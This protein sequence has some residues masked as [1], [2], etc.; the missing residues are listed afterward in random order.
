MHSLWR[1]PFWLCRQIP[2]TKLSKRLDHWVVLFLASNTHSSSALIE[3]SGTLPILH[4]IK[5]DKSISIS[6]DTPMDTTVEFVADEKVDDIGKDDEGGA[7]LNGVADNDNDESYNDSLYGSSDDTS[8]PEEDPTIALIH[9]L[10]TFLDPTQ[11]AFAVF[12]CGGT[13][14]IITPSVP[15]ESETAQ[16]T[17]GASGTNDSKPEAIGPSV[18]GR[19][20]SSTND[21]DAASLTFSPPVTLRWDSPGATALCQ[22]LSFPINEA[23]ESNLEELLTASTPAPFGRGGEDVCDEGYRKAPKLERTQFATTFNPYELGIIDTIAQVLLP[24]AVDLRM[25]GAVRAELFQLHVSSSSVPVLVPVCSLE[26]H[27]STR[28]HPGNSSPM[29]THLRCRGSLAL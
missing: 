5:K 13:I 18:D 9:D 15:R 6:S 25:L 24:S 4:P 20:A 17:A 10:S 27:R 28:L 16:T 8:V 23:T 12:A 26:K 1:S 29:S 2:F 7:D 19:D 22:K 21:T 11:D 14:A 3:R